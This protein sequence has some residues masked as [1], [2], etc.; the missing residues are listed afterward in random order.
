MC[1]SVK[2]LHWLWLL[3]GEAMSCKKKS[4]TPVSPTSMYKNTKVVRIH[5]KLTLKPVSVA[6]FHAPDKH[7]QFFS[8][9]P[10][11]TGSKLKKRQMLCRQCKEFESG[12]KFWCSECTAPLCKGVCFIRYHTNTQNFMPH[13][14]H[15]QLEMVLS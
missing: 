10:L 5:Q 15:L 6:R 9:I 11:L 12:S 13:K 3:N 1:N 8:A 7:A 14:N 2:V 4:P